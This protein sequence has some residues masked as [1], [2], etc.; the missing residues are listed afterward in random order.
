MASTLEKW[1]LDTPGPTSTLEKWGLDV[2]GPSPSTLEKWGITAEEPTVFPREGFSA[3][4]PSV[5]ADRQPKFPEI[6]MAPPP[7][8]GFSPQLEGPS[9]EI[10]QEEIDS[11]KKRGQEYEKVQLQQGLLKQGI[12]A[13]VD[14]NMIGRDPGASD[15]SK[16][17]VADIMEGYVPPQSLS[18]F[19][20]E[21]LDKASQEVIDL[22]RSETEGK[23]AE[24]SPYADI[25]SDLKQEEAPGTPEKGHWLDRF[26]SPNVLTEVERSEMRPAGP[27]EEKVRGKIGQGGES[28]LDAL[29]LVLNAPTRT[30]SEAFETMRR[31]ANWYGGGM[32][33]PPP[34]SHFKDAI[35]REPE[36]SKGFA[37]FF[38]NSYRQGV[39][40]RDPTTL[41][42][43]LMTV[44][45]AWFDMKT[46]G[47][48]LKKIMPYRRVPAKQ[49]I[50]ENIQ[51]ALKTSEVPV[52]PGP[53]EIN[54]ARL[55]AASMR[56]ARPAAAPA[57]IAQVRQELQN[58][59]KMVGMN[60]AELQR[61]DTAILQRMGE[62]G[63]FLSRSGNLPSATR[64][65]FPLS[66]ARLGEIQN[67]HPLDL[68]FGG[69]QLPGKA[70]EAGRKILS[71]FSAGRGAP[72][73]VQ[74][75]IRQAEGRPL[76]V[77]RNI[78]QSAKA[79]EKSFIN[80]ERAGQTTLF[81]DA[82]GTRLALDKKID[83]LTRLER[84]IPG[85]TR[86][87]QAAA[88]AREEEMALGGWDLNT[89]AEKKAWKF[90]REEFDDLHK[91]E[92]DEGIPVGFVD[93]Y[94]TRKESR[95][96][97]ALRKKYQGESTGKGGGGVPGFAK[98]R[99]ALEAGVG[100]EG[101]R[102]HRF[103]L[104]PAIIYADRKMASE[105]SRAALRAEAN[106]LK[107]YGTKMPAGMSDADVIAHYEGSGKAAKIW[108]QKLGKE[109]GQ[110]WIIDP[111]TE[112]LLSKTFD[113]KATH[114]AVKALQSVMSWW[115]GRATV[116]KPAFVNRN[117]FLG[118]LLN[119]AAGDV[120]MDPRKGRDA[121]KILSVWETQHF[122]GATLGERVALAQFSE[123]ADMNTVVQGK[124]IKEWIKLLERNK[125]VSPKTMIHA[126]LQT[127]DPLDV[128]GPKWSKRLNPLSS[129]NI[130]QEFIS[131]TNSKIENMSKVWTFMDKIGKGHQE[132]EASRAVA[133]LVFNYDELS[134]VLANPATTI[135]SAFPKWKYKNY[136]LMFS[137]LKD[138]P[139]KLAQLLSANTGIKNV[140]PTDAQDLS[141]G[142]AVTQ[143]AI[144]KQTEKE[145]SLPRD[146]RGNE[147]LRVPFTRGEE[148]SRKF[149]PQRGATP[150]GQLG[151]LALPLLLKG[152]VGDW[153][154]AVAMTLTD[155]LGP[156]PNY[157]LQ[158]WVLR[159][160]SLEP[161]YA[162][163][164]RSTES[165]YTTAPTSISY[166]M[167]YIKNNHAE[168]YDKLVNKSDW[169]RP[170]FV[171]IEGES[172]IIP[173]EYVWKQ[174]FRDFMETV[175]PA[176]GVVR[177]AFPPG[178]DS[179]DYSGK[180]S[181]F[182]W[183]KLTDFTDTR[184][185]RWNM[186]KNKEEI[187]D[188]L[189]KEKKR[190]KNAGERV[191]PK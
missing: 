116:T 37:D 109:A 139:D 64:Q 104:Q 60:P 158:K 141:V 106:T 126:E 87:A 125:V 50:Q 174:G 157:M 105:L 4:S 11:L 176:Q 153:A 166:M 165:N 101:T 111:R 26:I 42:H 127:G 52:G 123:A 147:W 58:M 163:V 63:R 140:D 18:D 142:M 122:G 31:G 56:S 85:E 185:M 118:N 102:L 90:M 9:R 190:Q 175:D 160:T 86:A 93:N 138:R 68:P 16:N 170:A 108:E 14:A 23:Q 34:H 3:E 41:E 188:E 65:V 29:D 96:S 177:R 187:L 33:G 6:S 94:I 159:K 47:D 44:L 169:V 76:A 189:A 191:N 134:R 45:G 17:R 115:K 150:M 91:A 178:K 167:E 124:T 55:R 24:T 103:E 83:R 92:V 77:S 38:L 144:D 121:L 79:I 149:F 143:G 13:V 61:L 36:G 128:R 110:K 57:R 186:K 8:S 155:W 19:P 162:G 182:G 59:G 43:A 98:P 129:E 46:G 107:A 5:L 12:K 70:R 15:Y 71:V 136:G 48:M 137:S 164:R 148:G 151:E 154:G 168:L 22:L 161:T 2:P 113:F 21:Q 39:G 82:K 49:A 84:P 131:K 172:K 40:G 171:D 35:A 67:P 28:T 78:G 81:Q 152:E 120:S 119:M 80:P 95:A 183:G 99:R 72:E 181:V 114:A 32:E 30:L 7:S 25:V 132:W 179:Q 69:E 20:K 27:V 135:L 88:V 74:D 117:F 66:K 130:V 53:G 75:V 184:M 54:P 180:H 97:V 100:A 10:T 89:P 145:R 73:G 62:Q 173:G 156:I 112:D 51:S 146:M 1:G 133:D